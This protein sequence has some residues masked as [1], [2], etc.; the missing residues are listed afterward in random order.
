MKR[1]VLC[2]LFLMGL[3]GAHSAWSAEPVDTSVCDILANP[4]SF[5]GKIIRL[6]EATVTTGFDEFVIDGSTC[7]SPESIWL[8]Y[9]EGTKGKAGPTALLRLQLAKNNSAVASEAP[10]RAAV[11]L[12]KDNNFTRFDS[13]LA[14]PYKP[15]ACLGCPRYSVSATLVGRLDVATR[16]TIEGFGNAN[17]Y[18]TRLVLQSV[19]DVVPHEINYAATAARGDLKRARTHATREQLKRAIDAFGAEGEDN[20]VSVGF[21]VANEIA[22]NEFAKGDHNS[23]DGILFYATFNIERLGEEMLQKAMAHIGAHIADLPCA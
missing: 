18:R 21:G 3:F 12:Q 17:L 5:D 1:L 22:P 9:P 16:K 8:A 10:A 20:G 19:S 13:L 14:E 23:P 15:K 6:K 4:T 7:S 11:T 2:S